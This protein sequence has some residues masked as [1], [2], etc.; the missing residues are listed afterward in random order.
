MENGLKIFAL[1]FENKKGDLVSSF[2]NSDGSFKYNPE[3]EIEFIG[4]DLIE[5]SERLK[6][7]PKKLSSEWMC[8]AIYRDV[9]IWV[10]TNGQ[11]VKTF[12]MCFS[13]DHYLFSDGIVEEIVIPISS[14]NNIFEDSINWFKSIFKD[15]EVKANY[16]RLDTELNTFQNLSIPSK[17]FP[18][19]KIVLPIKRSWLKK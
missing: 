4:V 9:L 19:E 17:A 11:I 13:C 14:G 12:E 7:F 8:G 1:H 10:D 18:K 15:L 5:L 3:Y 2:L 6:L 16:K